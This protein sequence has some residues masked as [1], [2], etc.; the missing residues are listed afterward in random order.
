MLA[1]SESLVSWS[2]YLEPSASPGAFRH[3][4]VTLDAARKRYPG[5]ELHS[6]PGY[7]AE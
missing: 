3:I 7:Y 5:A 4:T 2:A 6:R 1:S